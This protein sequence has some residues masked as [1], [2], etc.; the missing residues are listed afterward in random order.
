MI[1]RAK[2]VLFNA[3]PL[4][5]FALVYLAT[6]AGGASS[7]SPYLLEYRACRAL[8]TL[9]AGGTLAIAGCYLQATLRNPLV[10][11]HILG[12]GSGALFASYVAVIFLGYTLPAI[13]VSAIVGGLVALALTT[14][15]S[16]RISGSDV[17]Y[18]LT[19][20]S[21]MSLFSG[22]SVL[23]SYYAVTKYPH[24]S[25]MLVGS[26][27]LTTRDKLIPALFSYALVYS[28]YISFSKRLNALLLGDEYAA[29]LGVNPRF[30]RLT[31]A[32]VSGTSASI[33]VSLF[34]LIGFVGLIAPHI[35]RFLLGT[36]DNRLVIPLS[37][38]LGSLILYAADAFSRLVTSPVMGEVPAGAVV[39]A[40]GAPFFTLLVVKRLGRVNA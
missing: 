5:V 35:S 26:F 2:L 1:T 10:D 25:L 16:E 29:Q 9:L 20:I 17:A 18:V 13:S 14:L 37:A 6:Y 32:V 28:A 11:H 34:G 7:V 23:L 8:S 22:L 12:V 15:I 36:S 4:A 3:L 33:V 39:S 38:A 40:L 31:L 21:I 27:T 19:G 24:A 30:T